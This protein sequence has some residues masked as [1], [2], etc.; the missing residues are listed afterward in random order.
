M[1]PGVAVYLATG[2]M[3]V[4]VEATVEVGAEVGEEV[5][6]KDWTERVTVVEAATDEA[7]A[8]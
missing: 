8:A 5:V 1:T 4:R 2:E 7:R 3:V 6:A